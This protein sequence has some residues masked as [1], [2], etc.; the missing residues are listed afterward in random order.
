MSNRFRFRAIFWQAATSRPQGHHDITGPPT[1][2]YIINFTI[3]PCD[4]HAFE[5]LT[6]ARDDVAQLVAPCRLH[7][8][9]DRALDGGRAGLIARILRTCRP[10]LYGL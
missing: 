4:F 10:S 1:H 8:P 7:E 5:R 2:P 9:R 3:G 6:Q